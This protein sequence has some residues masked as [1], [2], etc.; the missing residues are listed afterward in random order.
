M[1]KVKMLENIIVKWDDYGETTGK[2]LQIHFSS[3][4][5]MFQF[6]FSAQLI[7]YSTY[8]IFLLQ[9]VMLSRTNI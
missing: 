6:F 4:Y 3:F 8:L 5:T 7:F 2:H 9:R 1:V